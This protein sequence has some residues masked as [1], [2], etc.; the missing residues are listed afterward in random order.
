LQSD[1]CLAHF[2]V[3]A[4]PVV[5]ESQAGINTLPRKRFPV[6]T[7]PTKYRGEQKESKIKSHSET[8]YCLQ[9]IVKKEFHN[10]KSNEVGF[11]K[12]RL[13]VKSELP[14]NGNSLFLP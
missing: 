9:S 3:T 13:V 5:Q 14:S 2:F 10:K 7:I 8:S 12:N 4:H 6:I 11:I 1:R